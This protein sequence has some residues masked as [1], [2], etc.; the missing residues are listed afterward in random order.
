MKIRRIKIEP[1]LKKG[2]E[3]IVGLE[4]LGFSCFLD[5]IKR[6]KNYQNTRGKKISL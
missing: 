3:S 1:Q 5:Q 2:K 4:S 6:N